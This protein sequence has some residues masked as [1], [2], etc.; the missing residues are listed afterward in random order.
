MSEKASIEK[1]PSESAVEETSL[2]SH[3]SE[4]FAYGGDDTL[5]PP[6]TLS[7]EEERRLWR[8][9]D[10]RLMPILTL[11]YLC[12]FLDRGNIGEW[13][14]C[15][16]SRQVRR[17]EQGGRRRGDGGWDGADWGRDREREAAGADDA[18]GADGE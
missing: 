2:K 6:P 9:V 11:M 18:A 8:K 7:A 4:K 12:S 13:F 5:P 16:G 10:M 3:K 14:A 1:L 17:G 15:R